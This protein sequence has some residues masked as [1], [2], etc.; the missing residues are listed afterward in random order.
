MSAK[1]IQ[2]PGAERPS[3]AYAQF[4]ANMFVTETQCKLEEVADGLASAC[5]IGI[6]KDGS[7]IYD[8]P[9]YMMSREAVS[10]IILCL[11]EI[12]KEMPH[13]AI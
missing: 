8:G 3:S 10:N 7:F 6:G 11:Q 1:I 2:F 9:D 12:L 5:F 4:Q 13:D